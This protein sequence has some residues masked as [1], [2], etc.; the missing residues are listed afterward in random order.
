LFQWGIV[1]FLQIRKTWDKC[2]PRLPLRGQALNT[3][4]ASGPQVSPFHLD[5]GRLFDDLPLK[6]QPSAYS[7]SRDWAQ[8]DFGFSLKVPLNF[9]LQSCDGQVFPICY[10]RNV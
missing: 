4:D 8:K 5:T 9:P 1:A 10:R 3:D 2:L 6:N 7:F